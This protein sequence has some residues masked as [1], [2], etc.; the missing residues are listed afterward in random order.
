MRLWSR[1]DKLRRPPSQLLSE[2][3]QADKTVD[4][5]SL[6]NA[7]EGVGVQKQEI[8]GGGGGERVSVGGGNH[9]IT[10]RFVFCI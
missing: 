2:L 4:Q 1:R 6:Q 9:G 7:L 8:G 10:H 5:E 3:A